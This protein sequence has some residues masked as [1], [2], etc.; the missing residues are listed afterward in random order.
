MIMNKM[1]FRRNLIL[2]AVLLCASSMSM[3]MD[4]SKEMTKVTSVYGNPTETHAMKVPK[5]VQFCHESIDLRR[6]DVRERFDRELMAMN[7]M[8][9]ATLQM[10]KRANRYFPVIEPILKANNVPDDMKY[11]CC[12]E[13]GMNPKSVSSVG[14][15]GLWQF[16]SSTAQ[17]YGLQVNSDVDE[18]YHIEKSTVAACQYLKDAYEI[19]KDWNLVAASYNAGK[20]RITQEL[21]KQK[22]DNYFDLYLNEETSRYVY[23]IL[24]CKWVLEHLK[25]YGFHLEAEDLYQ[26][27][28]YKTVIVNTAVPDWAAFAVE[29]GTTYK[30]LKEANL[31]IKGNV[32]LNKAGRLYEVKIPA[33]EKALL[34]DEKK[35]KT[36]QPA[37]IYE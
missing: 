15:A 2:M 36:H 18:R 37:W 34:F 9:S 25:D 5:Q 31:W 30:Q 16:M 32:M 33:S 23:R 10:I 7:F 12:I 26:P 14:A 4:K 21:E 13:S 20:R 28:A 29:Q 17:E 3:A 35:L 11:L 27:I 1:L 8:H 6:M 22:V 24:A 19:Y